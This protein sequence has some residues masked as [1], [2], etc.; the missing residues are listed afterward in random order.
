M[1]S[2][3]DRRLD[4]GP[5]SRVHLAAAGGDLRTLIGL[6]A[7]TGLRIGE[8]IKLDRADIDWSE[9]VLLI[10]ESKF[11][12][13]RL[14]PLHRRRSC[15]RW[16]TTPISATSSSRDAEAAELLRLPHPAAAVL[17]R[18]LPDVPA[19]SSTTAGIG[20]RRTTA[21]AAARPPP[22]FRGPDPARLV[23]HPARTC[24]PRSRRCRPTSVTANPAPPT[25]IC[26]R[27]PS[28]SPAPPPA[29]TRVVGGD[30]H[31]PDRRH[32]AGV[33]H[34][35][36]R[37]P[38]P[39]QPAHHRRLPRHAET[40]ARSSSTSADG[41]PP[42]PAGLGRPGRHHDLRV[43]QPPGDRTAQQRPDPQRAADRDPVA[44][45]LRRAAPSRA[46]PADPAGPGDPAETVRQAD[47]VVPDRHRDRRPDSP[48]PT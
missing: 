4:L 21:A 28:C 48:P 11:G 22:H 43:P 17:R 27:L 26:P 42:D 38:T 35:P 7:A 5:G 46:R 2:Y 40:A 19:V 30:A 25:G 20:S 44:V 31:D 36:A 32:P 29:R 10:R 39:R 14:V 12:K 23:S 16:P 18:C 34:R 45:L 8:A 33:L 9:G 3:A 13:S 41:K 1:R 24:R 47:R 6:L 15:R 37:Q